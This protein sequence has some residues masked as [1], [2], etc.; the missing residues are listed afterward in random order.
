MKHLK[1]FENQT[2]ALGQKQITPA[3]CC[4]KNHRSTLFIPKSVGEIATIIK[5]FV[6]NTFINYRGSETNYPG[7]VDLGLPS[8]TKWAKCNLGATTETEYGN[9]YAWG[10]IEPKASYSWETYKYGSSSHNL[11]KYNVEASR[12]IV[13][14]KTVLDPEDDAV[15]QATNG[16]AHMPT[17]EQCQELLDG[18]TNEWIENY[19]SSGVNG[20]LLTSKF[21]GN[22]IFIPA[23]GHASRDSVYGIGNTYYVW[24]ASLDEEAAGSGWGLFLDYTY[25]I[26]NTTNNRIWGNPIRGCID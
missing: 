24:A 2:Q 3:V 13:D 8:G 15:Y 16:V 12:G 5:D 21:N 10:E 25:D 17:K 6:D 11:T 18:T 7:Y 9:Y 19:Q 1:L 14:N 26:L 20:S 22:S 23:A 4:I